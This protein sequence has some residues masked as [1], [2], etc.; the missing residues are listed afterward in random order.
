MFTGYLLILSA[1][2][3]WGLIGIFSSLAFSQGVEPMEVAFWRALITW[4]CFGAQAFIRKETR[5]DKKDLPLL[6]VF[7]VFGIS[8]FYI[9]YQY[10]VKTG[11]AAF[12]AVLLY[13]APAWVVVFSYFIYREKLTKIKVAAVILVISGV[14]LISKTGGNAHGGATLGIVAI[15]SGLTSGFCYSLY[16]TI[17]KYFSQKYSSS[18][19]FLYVLPIGMLGILPFVH[20]VHKTPLAWLALVSVS[21]ISTFIANYCY[22]NGLKYLE[23][24]RA[25]IVATIEP[26]IAAV[27]AYVFLGEYFTFLGYWGAALVIIAVVATIYEKSSVKV[28][29]ISE[30]NT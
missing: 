17:G 7:A 9:A 2:S 24:G 20:F 15:V 27:A 22:Y 28:D 14:Y 8:V 11:G 4:I 12:A 10:A 3:C 25:S 29:I 30:T 13:T 5:V 26:V 18:T 16:Y 6:A 1:A 21:V 19:L 23:A